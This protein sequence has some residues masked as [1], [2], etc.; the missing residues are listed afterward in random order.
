VVGHGKRYTPTADDFG[1]VVHCAGN[2]NNGG[3]T[4]WETARAPEI[5]AR[6]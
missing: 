6:D 1:K 2:A 3:V 4:V 5:T